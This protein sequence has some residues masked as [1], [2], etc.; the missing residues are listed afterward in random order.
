MKKRKKRSKIIKAFRRICFIVFLL[1]VLS[2]SVVIGTGWIKYNKV[3]TELSVDEAIEEIRSQKNYTKIDDISLTFINA[4]VAVEDKRFYD[5]N[6]YDLIGIF[7]AVTNNIRSKE[8]SEGGSSITQQLAKNIYFVNDNTLSRKTAEIFIAVDL[9]EKLSK[10]EI[11]ELYFNVIYYGSGYYNIYDAAMGYFNKLPSELSDYEATL[12]AGIPNAPSVYSL[13]NNPDL[14]KQ[15][16][17]KVIDAML[18][19]K[20]LT[21]DEAQRILSQQE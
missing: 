2:L 21:N 13:N 9:E 4:M 11:L 20:Y 6:G 17:R 7:R 19:M 1:V 3:T 16:Q 14:A 5:H 18:A 12:L 15:R 10:K 8:L